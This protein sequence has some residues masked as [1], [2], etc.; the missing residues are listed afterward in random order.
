M[1]R[2]PLVARSP[3]IRFSCRRYLEYAKGR[4]R[5]FRRRTVRRCCRRGHRKTRHRLQGATAMRLLACT[6][7]LNTSLPIQIPHPAFPFSRLIPSHHRYPRRF[8][9]AWTSRTRPGLLP[10]PSAQSYRSL[11]SRYY[12]AAPPLLARQ[13]LV[14]TWAEQPSFDKPLGNKSSVSPAN[15][16]GMTFPTFPNPVFCAHSTNSS[17]AQDKL[18]CLKAIGTSSQSR[19]GKW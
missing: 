15:T 16:W 6:R 5:G 7:S 4:R 19:K 3:R 18:A 8:P 14:P 17:S 11:F 2:I 13:H 1:V 12:R 9:V 10:S